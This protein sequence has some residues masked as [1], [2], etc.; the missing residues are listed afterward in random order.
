MTTEI[1]ILIA[2]VLVALVPICLLLMPHKK[3]GSAKKADNYDEERLNREPITEKLH[4]T[5]TEVNCT[6]RSEGFRLPRTVTEFFIAFKDDEGKSF[7]LSVDEASYD[8][9][10][11]GQT[12]ELTLV[13]GAL[14]SFVLDE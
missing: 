6:V 11:K 4:V 12:G 14:L 10:D 8:G 2:I 3:D 5:V 9:F 1:I 13:D 7:V